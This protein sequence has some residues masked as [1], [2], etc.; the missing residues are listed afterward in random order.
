MSSFSIDDKVELK[1]DFD[2]AVRLGEF[3]VKYGTADKQIYALGMRLM[4]IE[5]KPSLPS[6]M[7]NGR[8]PS[9]APSADFGEGVE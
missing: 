3:I 5:G 8:R 9:M 4:A 1:M 6:P 2:L 7:R